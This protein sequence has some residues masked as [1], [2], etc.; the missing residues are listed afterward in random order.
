MQIFKH[1]MKTLSWDKNAPYAFILKS[2]K[3]KMDSQCPRTALT[4]QSI[5]PGTAHRVVYLLKL[6]SSF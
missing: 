3:S 4:L 1:K 2:K 6:D 5:L